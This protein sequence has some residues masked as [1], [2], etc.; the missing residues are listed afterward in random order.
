MRPRVEAHFGSVI[1]IRPRVEAPVVGCSYWDASQGRGPTTSFLG[2][3][4]RAEAHFVSGIGMRPRVEA[5][6]VGYSYWDK[7]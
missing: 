1:R 3:R 6:V 4:P 2:M 7:S 5:P